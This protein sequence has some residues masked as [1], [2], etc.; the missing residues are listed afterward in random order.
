MN[1]GQTPAGNG[2]RAAVKKRVV[3]LPSLL[4]AK[5]FLLKEL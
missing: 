4:M 1:T 5:S 2:T 3:W